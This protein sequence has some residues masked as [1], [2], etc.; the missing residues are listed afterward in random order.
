MRASV[1]G[2]CVWAL[3]VGGCAT[4]GSEAPATDAARANADRGPDAGCRVFVADALI[5]H[6]CFHALSGPFRDVDAEADGAGAA[7][8]VSRA[9]TAFQLRLAPDGAGAFRADLRYHAR[10][11][12]AYAIFM[13]AP[14]T[15][16]VEAGGAALEPFLAHE[17]E[18]C[19]ELPDVLGYELSEGDHEIA[20]SS[21][22]ADVTLV[23]ESMDEGSV[24]DGYRFDCEKPGLAD[25][26]A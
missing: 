9:H 4:G 22:H 8:D 24:E 10:A 2:S 23:I 21:E 25:L 17:T 3:L 19:P 18:L 6:S 14:S 13:S 15:L 11:D 7:P 12:A 26:R 5:E 16:S 20:V 1:V